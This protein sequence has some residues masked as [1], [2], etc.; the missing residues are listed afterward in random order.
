MPVQ[1]AKQ[2][3][4]TASRASIESISERVRLLGVYSAPA[5]PR[6]GP[7]RFIYR[8]SADEHLRGQFCYPDPDQM[9]TNGECRVIMSCG[10]RVTVPWA[11]LEPLT[12]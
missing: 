4:R 3:V 11:S 12:L 7:A 8:G 2:E 5:R 1:T 6:V 10:C 9:A